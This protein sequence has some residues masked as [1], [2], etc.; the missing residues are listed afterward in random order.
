MVRS[1]SLWAAVVLLLG[2]IAGPSAA[3]SLDEGTVLT[4]DNVEQHL[5]DTFQGHS[6]RELLRPY[7][8]GDAEKASSNLT[9]DFYR[10]L[11]RRY[12]LRIRLQA[13]H[14]Y[15]LDEGF[16]RATEVH[17]DEVRYDP[18][19]RV[20]RGYRA[21]WPFPWEELDAGDAGLGDKIFYNAFY[22]IP[23]SRVKDMFLATLGIDA[24]E[25]LER[26]Q[27][28]TFE[29]LN[30]YGKYTGSYAGPPSTHDHVYGSGEDS[31]KHRAVLLFLT[32]PQSV[33]GVGTFTVQYAPYTRRIE[34]QWAYVR[35]LRRTRRV[36]AG[37][38][39][40]KGAGGND[41]FNDEGTRRPPYYY[42]EVRYL[43]KR[44]VLMPMPTGGV[45]KDVPVNR[46]GAT[47]RERYPFMQL[48]KAPHWNFD[49]RYVSYEP[50]EVWVVHATMPEAHPLSERTYFVDPETGARALMIDYDKAGNLWQ[51]VQYAYMMV[52]ND[53]GHLGLIEYMISFN[54]LKAG[55]A[56]IAAQMSP[57]FEPPEIQAGDVSLN[58]LRQAEPLTRYTGQ[59]A[60]PR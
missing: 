51:Y 58:Q 9:V 41:Q 25:G 26:E 53:A 22:G 27:R 54:D 1:T 21:G 20:V 34:D 6:V 45:W 39:M 56:T 5:D 36:S 30:Y 23:S 11:M 42:P 46:E 32:Y 8:P 49:P 55:H 50:R 16:H 35:S 15:T 31:E 28:A 57:D 3:A 43:G 33:R 38:W 60:S 24:E 7:R 12:N 29:S 40:T 37:N 52:E 48:G 59:L 18:E 4:A 17:A 47:A 13:H 10:R 44:T 14:E 2:W 19:T